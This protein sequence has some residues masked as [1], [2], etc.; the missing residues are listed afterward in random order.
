MTTD[1]KYQG[2][3]NRETWCVALWLNNEQVLEEGAAAVCN[4][5]GEMLQEAAQSLENFV[6]DMLD[7]H[8]TFVGTMFR[9]LVNCC[10]ARVNW[11]EIAETFRGRY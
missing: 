3:T 1:E 5:P 9:D 2:W 4:Q 6:D 7:D 10:L 8:P 11:R